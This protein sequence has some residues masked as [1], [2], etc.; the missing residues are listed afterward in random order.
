MLEITKTETKRLTYIRIQEKGKIY[1]QPCKKHEQKLA[2][3][4][5]RIMFKGP[6]GE[7][8]SGKVREI[9]C[10]G[11]LYKVKKL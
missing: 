4:R 10:K 11:R 7:G 1:M 2:I 8:I 5:R 6:L 9:C 3:H